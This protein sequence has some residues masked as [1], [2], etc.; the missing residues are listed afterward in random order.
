[1]PITVK[2]GTDMGGLAA[3]A[4]LAGQLSG[5]AQRG[6]FPVPEMGG[7][8]GGGGR[9]PRY[10]RSPPGSYG[11]MHDQPWHVAERMQ[12]SQMIEEAAQAQRETWKYEYTEKQKMERARREEARRKLAANPDFTPQE[13][14]RYMKLSQLEDLFDGPVPREKTDEELQM[15]QW[16]KEGKGIG[17]EWEDEW[18]NVKTRKPTGEI[19]TQTPFEKTRA[20]IEMKLQA[21]R[22]AA[23]AKRR[24][25]LTDATLGSGDEQRPRYTD[26][27]K[28]KILRQ[29]FRWYDQQIREEIANAVAQDEALAEWRKAEEALRLGQQEA[30]QAQAEVEAARPQDLPP[31]VAD[32]HV[33]LEQIGTQFPGGIPDARRDLLI[34]AKQ[35]SDIIRE[36]EK[37]AESDEAEKKEKKRSF[38]QRAYENLP[39]GWHGGMS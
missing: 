30:E 29:E 20:G 8:G 33:F 13:K 32:A 17:Q 25:Q 4:L 38:I 21:D 5:S 37:P 39:A 10:D 15:E 19:V 3:L 1:M 12:A 28:D 23:L 6:L 7:G 34:L 36:Y 2:H 22:E 16:A 14:E 11:T 9:A 31:D 26:A 27:E 35:A 18:G 24:A